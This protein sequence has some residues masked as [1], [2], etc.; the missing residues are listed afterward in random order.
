MYMKGEGMAGVPAP[1]P[2]SAGELE[3]QLTV[4]IV[5]DID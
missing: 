2:I 4:Q 5:Y 1:T 3:F